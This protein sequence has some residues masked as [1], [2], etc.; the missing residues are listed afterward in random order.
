MLVQEGLWRH[1][2]IQT[3]TIH[4][5]L[6]R[7]KV[8]QVLS[9]WQGGLSE[10][11]KELKIVN[12][13]ILTPFNMFIKDPYSNADKLVRL[14]IMKIKVDKADSFMFP[15]KEKWLGRLDDKYYA[16]ITS[17]DSDFD[18]IERYSWIEGQLPRD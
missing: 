7:K 4:L 2:D 11:S 17:P 13:V 18:I 12:D 3:K 15:G 8:I 10:A 14:S 6:S 5:I 16:T 9:I 1:F